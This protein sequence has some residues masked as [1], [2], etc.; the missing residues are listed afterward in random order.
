MLQLGDR[1]K[2]NAL[3]PA[4]YFGNEILEILEAGPGRIVFKTVQ[5][6]MPSQ[7]GAVEEMTPG[8]V[9]NLIRSGHLEKID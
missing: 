5:A 1:M 4:H 3:I 6:D 8:T 7:V 9:T 2:V